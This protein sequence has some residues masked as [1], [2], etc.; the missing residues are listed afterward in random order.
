MGRSKNGSHGAVPPRGLGPRGE[1][2]RDLVRTHE[3]DPG[4]PDD[5]AIYQDL[6]GDALQYFQLEDNPK[7]G[8]RELS[9]L[10]NIDAFLEAR[11][12][13][14]DKPTRTKLVEQVAIALMLGAE[15]LKRREIGTTAPTRQ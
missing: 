10:F 14:V 13:N 1:W 9:R 12:L 6:L 4:D 11:G 3:D 5:W 8:V 7:Q 15:T 2:Y